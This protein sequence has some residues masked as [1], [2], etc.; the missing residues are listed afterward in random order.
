TVSS[1]G[2]PA[3]IAALRRGAT[4]PAWMARWAIDREVVIADP[5]D[6]FTLIRLVGAQKFRA[7]RLVVVAP[8]PGL[9]TRRSVSHLADTS[10]ALQLIV[11]T[12]EKPT[13]ELRDA[14]A[15][16]NGAYALVKRN[17]NVFELEYLRLTACEGV[18][19]EVETPGVVV[20]G[21]VHALD[22]THASLKVS[23]GPAGKPLYAVRLLVHESDASIEVFQTV[24]APP[25]VKAEAKLEVALVESGN[26]PDR[27]V[28]GVLTFHMSTGDVR[29]PLLPAQRITGP[30]GSVDIVVN[31]GYISA[32]P[33]S[34]GVL[35]FVGIER[36][37]RNSVGVGRGERGALSIDGIAITVDI[38]A[39]V[40]HDGRSVMFDGEVIRYTNALVIDGQAIELRNFSQQHRDELWRGDQRLRITGHCFDPREPK[41]ERVD[42]FANQDHLSLLFLHGES[43]VGADRTP[44]KISKHT[45]GYVYNSSVRADYDGTIVVDLAAGTVKV[46]LTQEVDVD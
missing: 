24:W 10:E 19:L 43:R 18:S 46:E 15:R 31:G 37:A 21:N 16:A 34:P 41:S 13:D 38:R 39:V 7:G 25:A 17:D 4:R 11:V 5:S 45:R 8:Q 35:A 33:P 20:N 40:T 27:T 3:G 6:A 30:T 28:D 23:G 32:R 14:L 2:L 36:L 9:V 22:G 29:H 12:T 44:I 1:W 26:E 42:A